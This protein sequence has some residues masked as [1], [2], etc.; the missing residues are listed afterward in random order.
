MQRPDPSKPPGRPLTPWIG[1]FAALVVFLPRILSADRTSLS[2]WP[3]V[4]IWLLVVFGY[5]IERDIR[6][7]RVVRGFRTRDQLTAYASQANRHTRESL[8][9][10]E[11][12][13][14][15]H[16]VAGTYSGEPPGA[17]LR[18]SDELSRRLI[19]GT[20][21]QFRIWVWVCVAMFVFVMAI[22][23]SSHDDLNDN[24]SA[25]GFI[26]ALLALTVALY[27]PIWRW[28]SRRPPYVIGGRVES[29]AEVA[30]DHRWELLLA[31]ACEEPALSGDALH[32]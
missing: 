18:E 10:T 1:L 11:Y 3:I 6:L 8:A 23:V 5:P 25:A 32:G 27:Y 16:V 22:I 13:I 2:V 19:S 26:A 4:A 24:L 20:R 28:W 31:L 21:L 12:A 7:R 15:R 17:Y 30:S 14:A 9:W 29:A